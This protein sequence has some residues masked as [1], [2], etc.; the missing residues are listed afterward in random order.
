MTDTT[1]P[2][3]VLRHHVTGAIERGEGEPVY[4]QERV[5][6]HRGEGYVRYCVMPGFFEAWTYDD[7]R[8]PVYAE[9]CT[10]VRPG[11][12][13]ADVLTALWV[14]M[15]DVAGFVPLETDRQVWQ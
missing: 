2:V 15:H 6:V 9:Q 12:L 3:D 14:T 1:Y 13:P 5:T 8:Q 7:D 11:D 10:P 4:A